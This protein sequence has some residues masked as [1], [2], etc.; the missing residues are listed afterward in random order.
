MNPAV[1]ILKHDVQ[2]PFTGAQ[3]GRHKL[4]LSRVGY[5][6][7]PIIVIPDVLGTGV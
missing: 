4:Q 5:S 3:Q 1:N 7:V 6:G 2:G